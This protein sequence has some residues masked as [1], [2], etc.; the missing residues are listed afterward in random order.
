MKHHAAVQTVRDRYNSRREKILKK[1][2]WISLITT[3]DLTIKRALN[4]G[5]MLHMY[6]ITGMKAYIRILP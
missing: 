5:V 2:L 1:L 6:T 3:A 4:R